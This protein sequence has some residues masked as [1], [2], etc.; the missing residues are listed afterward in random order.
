[1]K[2][3]DT[4]IALRSYFYRQYMYRKSYE[5][6]NDTGLPVIP[7]Q[8]ENIFLMCLCFSEISNQ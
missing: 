2:T 4:S 5:Y 1:M 6:R 7:G 8:M 3:S